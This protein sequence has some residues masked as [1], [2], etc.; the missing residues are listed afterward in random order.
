MKNRLINLAVITV[1]LLALLSCESAGSGGSSSPEP[2]PLTF[3]DAGANLTGV[4]YNPTCSIADVNN[5]GHTD[6]LISGH[7]SSGD[8][9]KLYLNDGTGTFSHANAGMANLRYTMSG[10]ADMDNDGDMDLCLAGNNSSGNPRAYLYINAGDGTFSESAQTV[11][12]A[13][14]GSLAFAD[15]DNDGNIDLLVCGKHDIDGDDNI[16]ISSILYINQGDNNSDGQWD[17]YQPSTE[18]LTGVR[19]GT[20]SFADI[21]NDGYPEILISGK[22]DASP[23]TFTGLYINNGDRTYAESGTVFPQLGYGQGTAF[24]D[25]NGDGDLEI[26]LAYEDSEL[27]TEVWGLNLSGTYEKESDFAEPASGR[28][29]S[30]DPD[31]DGD[32]DIIIYDYSSDETA[33]TN[34]YINDGSGL[35]SRKNMGLSSIESCGE[36]H[37]FDADGDS[38]LDLIICGK[39][40]TGSGNTTLYLNGRF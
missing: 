33:G 34:F 23:D 24:A 16:E 36:G 19:N 15:V 28:I 29:I 21:N 11:Y 13:S 10:F 1:V 32:I 30:G 39:D 26:L 22:A 8:V 31:S 7:S 40:S 38:D 6:L 3:S 27:K 9:T 17:G 2:G 12:G 37:F 4:R 18:S 35:F 25:V 20:C 5:D 14:D